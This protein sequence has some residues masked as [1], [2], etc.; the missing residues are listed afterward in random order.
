MYVVSVYYYRGEYSAKFLVPEAALES[1][2]N[3]MEP[4]VGV[5]HDEPFVAYVNDYKTYEKPGQVLVD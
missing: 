3:K 4:N 5:K 1:F 2:L